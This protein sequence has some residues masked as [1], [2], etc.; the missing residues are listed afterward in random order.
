MKKTGMQ[1]QITTGIIILDIF[2]L[3]VETLNT[4]FLK[5]VKMT[6]FVRITSKWHHRVG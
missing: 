2:V 1:P 5:F 3:E 6:C 4:F